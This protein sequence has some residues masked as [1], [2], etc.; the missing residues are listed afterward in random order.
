MSF[1]GV[2]HISGDCEC[3]LYHHCCHLN[4]LAEKPYEEEV[5]C[6]CGQTFPVL[7]IRPVEDHGPHAPWLYIP[8]HVLPEDDICHGLIDRVSQIPADEISNIINAGGLVN[9]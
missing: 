3:G 4:R 2:R 1:T 9:G 7:H 6:W 8:Q 5:C